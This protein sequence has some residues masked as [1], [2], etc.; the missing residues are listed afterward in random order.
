MP[1]GRRNPI[2]VSHI[3][4]QLGDAVQ[5][6][7]DKAHSKTSSLIKKMNEL[8]L[9]IPYVDLQIQVNREYTWKGVVYQAIF[10]RIVHW[11]VGPSKDGCGGFS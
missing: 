7:K 4:E 8:G 9:A 5:T 3:I 10:S 2:S 1:G 6:A 11:G